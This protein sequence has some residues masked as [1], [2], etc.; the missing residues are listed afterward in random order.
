MYSTLGLHFHSSTC[1]YLSARPDNLVSYHLTYDVKMPRCKR[2]YVAI[3]GTSARSIDVCKTIVSSTWKQGNTH[4]LIAQSASNLSERI[5]WTRCDKDDIGPSPQLDVGDPV[6]NL[7][8]R[9]KQMVHAPNP[10]RE[11]LP[12]TRRHQS[13]LWCLLLPP[14]SD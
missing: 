5:G 1:E 3:M 8:D 4:E 13:I 10:W 2:V 11:V 6:H 7:V 12:I 14:P 9:W